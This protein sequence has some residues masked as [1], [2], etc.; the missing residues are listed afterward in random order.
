MGLFLAFVSLKHT[1][2][3]SKLGWRHD[4]TL[5]C[6]IWSE[7][8]YSCEVKL[9]PH[10]I[11]WALDISA[12]YEKL[13]ILVWV[14]GTFSGN[15]G[16]VVVIHHLCHQ[17]PKI[18]QMVAMALLSEIFTQKKTEQFGSVFN[19][20]ILLAVLAAININHKNGH[21]ASCNENQRFI[22]DFIF[23]LNSFWKHVGL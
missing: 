12:D 21:H 5:H 18:T 16:C 15:V 14:G 7:K 23:I 22:R 13:Q 3:F 1:C 9:N 10:K 2:F 19:L 17:L 6:S 4:M 11:S 8:Y 20:N